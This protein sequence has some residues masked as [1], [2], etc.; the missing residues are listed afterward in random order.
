M[1]HLKL[2]SVLL[3]M[4]FTMPI[5]TSCSDDEEETLELLKPNGGS[6][7]GDDD[8]S[9]IDCNQCQDGTCIRCDGDGLWLGDYEECDKCGGSGLCWLCDGDGGWY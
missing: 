3:A 1:K 4:L 5:I 9:W 8:E 7:G 6:Y 2:F